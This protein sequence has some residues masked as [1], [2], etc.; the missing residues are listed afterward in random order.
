MNPET[1]KMLIKILKDR[2]FN[3]CVDLGCGEGYYGDVLKAHCDYL[4]GVDHNL[5]RLSVAKKYSG[6][7]EVHFCDVRDYEIPADTD[8]VFMLDLIEHLPKKDGFDLL[9]KV[10]NV[11][12]VLITTPTFFH[13]FTMFRNG[14]VSLW[15]EKELQEN[16]FN[17][18][19][20]NKGLAGL[21]VDGTIAWREI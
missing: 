1:K 20:Y 11:P 14:H 17:T 4:I 15:T 12:F 16:G 10:R 13:T 7:N 3:K 19:I 18:I 5:A 8:A 2:H 21:F 6:Y 9:L